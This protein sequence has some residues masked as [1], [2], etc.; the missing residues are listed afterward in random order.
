VCVGIQ[1]PPDEKENWYCRE[2]IQRKQEAV[3][4]K[5]KKTK[6]KKIVGL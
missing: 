5:K 3:E 6:K 4:D 1:V 2:C